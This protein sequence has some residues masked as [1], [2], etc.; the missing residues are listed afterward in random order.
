MSNIWIK[1]N[2][3]VRFKTAD[4]MRPY[5]LPDCKADA[6]KWWVVARKDSK[7][8]KE[9]YEKYLLNG[10]GKMSEG[11]ADLVAKRLIKQY[12]G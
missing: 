3:F 11:A 10:P 2:I 4:A 12:N 8:G 5:R 9:D 6:Y 1:G 7:N